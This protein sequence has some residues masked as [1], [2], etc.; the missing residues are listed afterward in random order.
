MNTRKGFPTHSLQLRQ[1]ISAALDRKQIS[2]ILY[3]GRVPAQ[4]GVFPA[5]SEHSDPFVS[6]TANAAKAKDLVAQSG[7]PA[8]CSLK[9]NVLGSVPDHLELAQLISQQLGAVGIKVAVQRLDDSIF[10]D[11]AGKGD[12]DLIVTGPY[13]FHAE[14]Y[15]NYVMPTDGGGPAANTGWTGADP[16]E[17]K[18]QSADGAQFKSAVKQALARV[19]AELPFV[20]VVGVGYMG[21]SRVSDAVFS[22]SPLLYFPVATS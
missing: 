15:M 1:A 13:G 11:R 22:Q 4:L 21:G 19:H 10:F 14:D 2:K 6:P 8:P 16:L 20:P 5:T 17:T 12:F 18:W 9:I 7:C 3:S